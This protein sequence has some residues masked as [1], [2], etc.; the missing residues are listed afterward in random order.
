MLIIV[1]LSSMKPSTKFLSA[2][3]SFENGSILVRSRVEGGNVKYWRNMERIFGAISVEPLACNW[4]SGKTEEF[5]AI[6]A[7]PVTTYNT[8]M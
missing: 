2:D 1:T 3:E 8:T 5:W 6:T 7:A 4:K